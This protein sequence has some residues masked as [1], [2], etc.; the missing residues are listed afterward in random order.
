[1]ELLF[2][3]RREITVSLANTGPYAV[4]ALCFRHGPLTLWSCSASDCS[5]QHSFVFSVP[6]ETG[7]VGLRVLSKMTIIITT[8]KDCKLL[9]LLK[10]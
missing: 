4:M 8:R 10:G 7:C 5:K 6:Q 1:M 3:S 9:H 2:R